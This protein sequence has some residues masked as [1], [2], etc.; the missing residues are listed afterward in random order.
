[1]I[2]IWFIL[3]KGPWSWSSNENTTK[4][5]EEEEFF[6]S[7]MA[8]FLELD[9]LRGSQQAMDVLSSTLSPLK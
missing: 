9:S 1:M 8:E 4:T 5:Q 7:E 3:C 6:V 2:S